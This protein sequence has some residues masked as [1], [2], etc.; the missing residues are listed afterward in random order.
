LF[1]I[2]L[3]LHLLGFALWFGAG[4]VV[5]LINSK[6]QKSN[7]IDQ[8]SI[9]VSLIDWLS[10]RVF[11]PSSLLTLISG[12][13]LVNISKRISFSDY[14]IVFSLFG[15]FITFVLGGII[16]PKLSNKITSFTKKGNKKEFF[17]THRNLIFI[18][19]LDTI[20]IFIIFLDMIFKPQIS[21]LYFHLLALFLL[22]SVSLRYLIVKNKVI[23]NNR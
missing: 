10:K 15:I 8:I 3:S 20:I 13:A 22:L 7:N 17:H 5:G 19:H 11:V 16:I 23:K 9:S 12:I 2:L 4:I 6:S 14:W 21:N 1:Q 18:L